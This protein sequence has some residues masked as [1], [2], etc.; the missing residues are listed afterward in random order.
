MSVFK[1]DITAIGEC[2]VELN[3]VENEKY[4]Q[5]YSGDVVNT[6]YY[7]SR[8]GLHGQLLTC[9]GEDPFREGMLAFMEGTNISTASILKKNAPNGVYF[10]RVKEGQ[11]HFHFLRKDSAATYTIASR[12][13]KEIDTVLRGARTLL[14]TGVGMAVL[15]DRERLL[16]CISRFPGLLYF[17]M[18]LR[19]KLWSDL[20][21]YKEI[22]KR[23]AARVD[24]LFVSAEDDRTLYG[25][26]STDDA[27]HFYSML[28]FRRVIYR[29]GAN[30]AIVW[31]NPDKVVIPAYKTLCVDATGAGDAFNAGVIFGD[32]QGWTSAQ[33]ARYGAA[34]A[35][36]AIG[37]RGGIAQYFT[38]ERVE[39]LISQGAEA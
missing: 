14:L 25:G 32:D 6:L 7:L 10:I 3:E 1:Y 33:V 35:A 15:K 24:C 11:P 36:I 5:A 19:K 31:N 39:A 28:G 26:R 13:D 16:Q 37:E 38:R 8:L 29:D 12:T 20:Q 4:T 30:G 23:I 17:D 27:I 34:C 9:V 18:N 22:L 2:L 21:E